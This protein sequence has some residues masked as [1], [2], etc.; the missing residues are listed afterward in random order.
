MSTGTDILAKLSAWYPLDG[1]LTDAH[2]GQTINTG[3][4]VVGYT[5]GMRSAQCLQKG[6]RGYCTLASAI[7][8]GIA[9]GTFAIGGWFYVVPSNN[10]YLFGLSYNTNNFSNEAFSFVMNSDNSVKTYGFTSA[11]VEYQ[12]SSPGVLPILYPITVSVEDSEAT[13]ATSDQTILINGNPMDP[14]VEGWYFVVSVWENGTGRMY[15]GDV[16]Q[17]TQP[18]PASVYGSTMP[19][20]QLGNLTSSGIG[21]AGCAGNLQ[22]VFLMGEV[23]TQA[24]ITWLYNGGAGRSYG[25]LV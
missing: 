7:P 22:D 2:G 12:I 6:S 14:V 23:P 15:I 3:L 13:V 19:V 20:F 25:D 21:V 16:L 10:G 18:P 11:L 24:E 4:T 9:S 5:S 17:D 1:D 8:I